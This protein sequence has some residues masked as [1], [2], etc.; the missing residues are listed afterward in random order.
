MS[1]VTDYPDYS[2]HVAHAQQIAATGVPLL[3]LSTPLIS[4]TS[5]NIAGNA[6][7]TPPVKPVS[8]IGY[9]FWL[10]AST[11]A[12]ATVPYLQVKMTWIDSTSG[13][14]VATDSFVVP[15]ASSPGGFVTIG[16]GPTKADQLSLTI[17]NLDPAV[18]AT[19]N[20]AI[21][22]NSRV[23]P[24][25]T[26]QWQMGNVVGVTVPG[27][28]LPT[29]P[30]DESVLGVLNSSTVA[31]SSSSGFL[32][33]M[34][35]GALVQLAGA[36]SGITPS[37]VG[38]IVSALPA[39]VYTAGGQLLNTVLTTAQFSYQFI[40]PRAPLFVQWSNNATSGTLS[41]SGMMTAQVS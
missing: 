32:F 16:R 2:P 37:N 38:L 11:G 22:Q 3:T 41:V 40:A 21:L 20:L 23:Y 33:G 30:D 28:T 4:T 13:R 6:V 35:P 12:A 1:V 9:E 29:L 36:T 14:A 5:Q 17:Q 39:G 31:A 15:A 8:Q 34:A 7:Y 25:D 26:W 27:F 19:I 10:Q 24:R 18:G